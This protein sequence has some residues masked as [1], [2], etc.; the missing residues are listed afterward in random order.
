MRTEERR[1]AGPQGSHPFSFLV[2]SEGGSAARDAIPMRCGCDARLGLGWMEPVPFGATRP[3]RTSQFVLAS[4]SSSSRRPLQIP[5]LSHWAILIAPS[6]IGHRRTALPISVADF[7]LAT[8]PAASQR[9][10][11][12]LSPS[13]IR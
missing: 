1:G 10:E 3:M 6:G 13:L 5:T 7:N 12:W 2:C 11:D 9:F 8:L 4:S